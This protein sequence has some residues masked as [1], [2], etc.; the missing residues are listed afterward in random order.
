MRNTLAT[1]TVAFLL[2]APAGVCLAEDA[3]QILAAAKQASGG[4]AWDAI[5]STHTKGR[6]ETGGLV[7][8]FESW[9]DVRRGRSLDRFSLGPVSG[10]QGFD[11]TSVWSQDSSGQVRLEQGGEAREAAANDAYRRSLAFWFPERW[12]ATI[13]LA[14]EQREG[15]RSFHVVRIT[16]KGGRPYDV[17]VDAATFLF[18]RTVEKTAAETRTVVLSDYREVGRVKLP[19][20]TRSGNGEVRYDQLGI[21]EK[22]E[23]NAPIDDSLF[24]APA[25]PPP[26]FVLADGKTSTSV[27]FEL[28][29]NHIYVQVRLNGKGPFRLLCDTGGANVVTPELAAE[30]GL[31]SEGALQ[32]RGVGEKSEDIAL[33]KVDTL[34]LGDVRLRDQV[35]LVFPLGPFAAV[36]GIPQ[37]GLVGYEVFK[38]FVVKVDYEKSLLTLTVPS[39]FSASATGTVVP[40]VFNNHVPQVEGEIDGIPGKFD[41]DTGSRASLS[42]LAPF[43]EKHGLKDRYGAKLAAMTGWGVGG[44]ARGLVTRARVLKLGG[45]TVDSPVIELSLQTKGAFTDPYV[46]GNVGAGVLKRF[47][48]T[49]DY[50]RQQLIFERNANDGV[51]DT[52]DRAGMWINLADGAFEVEDVVAGGPAAAAGLKI[53]DRILAIDG[54]EAARLPLPDARAALRTAPP[55]TRV[56][57]TLGPA[58]APR[59]VEVVLRDLV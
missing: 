34:Q 3:T 32:G 8:A 5:L 48:I 49:F 25:P 33:T 18:D 22:I 11:G 2:L 6:L 42:V 31:K 16:P 39:A 45:V 14:G 29:N 57:L 17:W 10:A 28:I 20:A 50:S 24:A 1:L 12:P 56:R 26:D 46:A 37:Y 58:D 35:F 41:I 38:R 44:A 52:Y 19:F 36:E 15:E 51:R 27:P 30:L 55:G 53:G 4:A 7:G 47:N 43:A 21:V 54:K 40:F 9:D 59:E 13:E 23:I